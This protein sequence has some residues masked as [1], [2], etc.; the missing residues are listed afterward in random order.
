MA[1]FRMFEIVIPFYKICMGAGVYR[2][3]YSSQQNLQVYNRRDWI[4]ILDAV[5]KHLH[6]GILNIALVDDLMI[7]EWD[8]RP[9]RFEVGPPAG[10]FV[11]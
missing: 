3:I 7:K 1:I 10:F 4:N 6:E 9:G 2:V 8:R 11:A 5:Q